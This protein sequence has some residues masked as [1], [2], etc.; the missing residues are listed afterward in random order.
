MK[1]FGWMSGGYLEGE[2]VPGR[3]GAR[4]S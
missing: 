3:S 4:L 2:E 1:E